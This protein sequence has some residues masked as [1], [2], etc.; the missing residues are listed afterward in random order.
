[1]WQKQIARYWNFLVVIISTRT[2]IFSY[3]GVAKAP[4][5]ACPKRQ[6]SHFRHLL[7]RFPGK[8]EVM[9]KNGCDIRIQHPSITQERILWCWCKVTSDIVG[10]DQSP[11]FISLSLTCLW[12]HVQQTSTLLEKFTWLVTENTRIA[13][14]NFPILCM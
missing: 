9:E 3:I 4:G 6:N 7:P 1:M 5:L 11:G 13:Q 12:V 10:A 14:E 8:L 2:L